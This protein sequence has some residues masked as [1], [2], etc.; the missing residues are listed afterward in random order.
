M[1]IHETKGGVYCTLM[2]VISHMLHGSVECYRRQWIFCSEY[3]SMIMY[4]IA[5]DIGFY[6]EDEHVIISDR[7]KELI[8]YKGFQVQAVKKIKLFIKCFITSTSKLI[9]KET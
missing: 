5:G 9:C 2:T 4:D 7:L 3:V 8:K 6:D 1:K